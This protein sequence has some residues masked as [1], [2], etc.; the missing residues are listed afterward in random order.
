MSN[1]HN[2]VHLQGHQRLPATKFCLIRLVVLLR[3]ETPRTRRTPLFAVLV[4]LCSFVFL[5]SCSRRSQV[6][7]RVTRAPPSA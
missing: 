6:A 2:G 3:R 1:T 4:I 5:P 7:L